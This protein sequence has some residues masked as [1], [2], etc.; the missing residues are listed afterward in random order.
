LILTGRVGSCI[1]FA[2]LAAH[3]N[4]TAADAASE[5]T[6]PP[7]TSVRLPELAS[8]FGK[9]PP[10]RIAYTDGTSMTVKCVRAPACGAQQS[11][12]A[13][14]QCVC[15]P[16]KVVVRHG[17]EPDKVQCVTTPPC[18]SGQTRDAQTGECRCLPGQMAYRSGS[19]GGAKC[20][21]AKSCPPGVKFD[22]ATGQCQCPPGTKLYWDGA[23]GGACV[24]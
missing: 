4:A 23:G 13:A 19:G 9:C 5:R 17:A 21:I 6:A 1:C 24:P 8:P 10:G 18:A 12:N 15:P 22:V 11:R 3:F 20:V 7:S 2:A 16:G 14:G